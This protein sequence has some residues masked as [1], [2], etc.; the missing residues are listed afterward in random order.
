MDTPR[1]LYRSV[2]LANLIEKALAGDRA[3]CGTATFTA[4]AA[5]SDDGDGSSAGPR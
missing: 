5:E 1:A 2:E 4:V 3:Q